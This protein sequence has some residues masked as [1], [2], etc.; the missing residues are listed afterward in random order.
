MGWGP[1]ILQTR[2]LQFPSQKV[3]SKSIANLQQSRNISTPMTP[4]LPKGFIY[5]GHGPL[6][7]PSETETHDILWRNHE[8]EWI[9]DYNGWIGCS[10]GPWAVREDSPIAIAN[11][12]SPDPALA[13]FSALAAQINAK[14]DALN[15]RLDRMEARAVTMESAADQTLRELPWN[16][17][18]LEPP[19]LPDGKTRWVNR[20]Y[21]WPMPG[22]ETKGRII[23]WLDSERKWNRTET[24][25]HA[26]IHH[27]EAV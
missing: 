9:D 15:A 5:A 10:D 19:P 24:F 12:L 17:D 14:L 3:Q 6:A 22:I 20:G 18:W 8:G 27:I 13:A 16:P 1:R 21:D 25:S 2:K 11:G 7:H 23:Y 4:P 26:G